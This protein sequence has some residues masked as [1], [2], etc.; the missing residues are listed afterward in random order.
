MSSGESKFLRAARLGEAFVVGG[1]TCGTDGTQGR[2][3]D[4]TITETNNPKLT[5]SN[6]TNA[7]NSLDIPAPQL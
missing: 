7:D 3:V 4:L 1:C 2:E 6:D 5:D